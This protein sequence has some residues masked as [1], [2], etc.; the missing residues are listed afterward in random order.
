MTNAKTKQ[1]RA[2]CAYLIQTFSREFDDA[3]GDVTG[4][5]THRHRTLRFSCNQPDTPTEQFHVPIA[6]THNCSS[7]TTG[8]TS[9]SN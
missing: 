7:T 8:L 2:T 1:S 3:F 5:R 6:S 9:G 4:F